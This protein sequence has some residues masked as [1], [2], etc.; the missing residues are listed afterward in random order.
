MAEICLEHSTGM[1]LSLS[2]LYP[3]LSLSLS[4][5]TLLTQDPP[6]RHTID[7]MHTVTDISFACSLSSSIISDFLFSYS[8]QHS[9][10]VYSHWRAALLFTVFYFYFVLTGPMKKS[11]LVNTFWLQFLDHTSYT[12]Y[13]QNVPSGSSQLSWKKGSSLFVSRQMALLLV[14]DHT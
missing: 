10:V 5:Q 11:Y 6:E 8:R 4:L 9:L 1:L 14:C 2:F 7:S 3:S 12:Y 13:G